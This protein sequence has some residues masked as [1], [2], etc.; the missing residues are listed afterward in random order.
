MNH[1]CVH[2]EL[3]TVFKIKTSKEYRKRKRLKA[4]CGIYNI[5]NT[6]VKNRLARLEAASEIRPASDSGAVKRLLAVQRNRTRISYFNGSGLETFRLSNYYFYLT[7]INSR[8]HKNPKAHPHSCSRQARSRRLA[9]HVLTII[10]GIALLTASSSASPANKSG[11]SP[12]LV[13]DST[14]RDFGDV[15]VGE[16]LDQIF[17]VRNVGTA[18]LE[19]ANKTL[20]ARSSAASPVELI[21]ASSPGSRNAL[22][23][24]L[25]P[26]AAIKGLAAPT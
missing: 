1:S 3:H 26:A 24:Y 22:S 8:T 16:E 13:I 20:A 23:S 18:P 11:A 5:V 6:S 15:F 2:T 9:A 21:R 17:T 4:Y 10:V 19:L 14:R 7:V 25:K 12:E